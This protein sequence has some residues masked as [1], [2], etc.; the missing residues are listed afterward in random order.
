MLKQKKEPVH[1]TEHFCLY[2]LFQ[3]VGEDNDTPYIFLITKEYT[4][5]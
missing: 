4:L 2:K 3:M 5:K 1:Q